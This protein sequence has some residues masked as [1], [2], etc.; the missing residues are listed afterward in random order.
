MSTI[1]ESVKAADPL[2]GEKKRALADDR[3]RAE[4]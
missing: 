2:A 1:S 3:E 4:T